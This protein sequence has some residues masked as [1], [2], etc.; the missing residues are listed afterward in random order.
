MPSPPRLLRAVAFCGEESIQSLPLVSFLDPL[1][2]RLDRARRRVPR[3]ARVL[4]VVVAIALPLATFGHVPLLA[5]GAEMPA[6][7]AFVFDACGPF[8]HQMPSRSF[9][10]GGHGFPLCARCTGMWLGITLGIAFA[11]VFVPRHRWW[12]GTVGAVVFTAASGFD[13]LREESGGTPNA[14]VRA[15]LGFFLFVGVT[16]AVS[17]DVLAVLCAIGR[18]LR[19]L[20]RGRED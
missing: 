19:R 11:M 16:L 20:H 17:F 6:W 14:W 18:R 7:E 3:R 10:L 9:H 2:Q 13:F 1:F 12:I 4:V 8:C 5:A 15:A